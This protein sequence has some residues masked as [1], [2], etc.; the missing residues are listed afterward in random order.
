M[1]RAS[2]LALFTAGA[3]LLTMTA[4]MD[5]R[6]LGEDDPNKRTREGAIIGG[7]VGAVSG[8]IIADDNK[9]GAILG[10]I[11]GATAGGL[12]GQ[13]LDAQE[14]ELRQSLD[15][16]VSITNTGDRLIVTM[17]QDILFAVDSTFVSGALR[18]DLAAVATSLNR[19]PE[20][21]V[22]VLGHTD[23]TGSAEYNLDLSQRRANSVAAILVDSGV[24]DYRIRPI[25]RGEDQPV[26]S[27]LTPEG[28]AQNRRVD[29]VILP[30]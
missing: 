11:A 7:L 14:A 16:R 2:K 17:P 28:R 25:G 30:N 4:C 6:Y 18:D 5:T 3:S 13:R 10:G 20:S 1:I 24:S 15:N 23:N 26:A 29:I 22:Q 9:K 12:I 21:T 27:N 19:Y 8:A